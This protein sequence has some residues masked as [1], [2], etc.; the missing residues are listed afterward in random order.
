MS[1]RLRKL[2][3]T[4]AL[5][6]LVVV[7]ALV[8]MAVAQPVLASGNR[9]AAPIIRQ[10]PDFVGPDGGNDTF[11]GFTLTSS[12]VATTI[13]GCQDNLHY[14]NFFGTSAAAPHAASI[15]A[16][17]QESNARVTPTQIYGAL[18][19]SALPMS[20]TTPN[21]NSGYGFIQADA[22]LPLIPPGAPALALSATTVARFQ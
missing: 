13:A 9:L 19:S 18:R 11:L 17:M 8:A 10:K 14:P 20:G 3:G 1:I 15:A 6:A 2:I 5:L 7:W 16:L 12:Q 22:S 21:F 4:I